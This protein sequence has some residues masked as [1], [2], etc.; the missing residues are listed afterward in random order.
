MSTVQDSWHCYGGDEGRWYKG[1]LLGGTNWMM[2]RSG[3]IAVMSGT[4]S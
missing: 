4:N 3:E 2:D 1:R